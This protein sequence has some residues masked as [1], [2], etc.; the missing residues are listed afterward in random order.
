MP[1]SNVPAGLTS[2]MERCVEKVMAGGKDK[3]A[4]IA[5]CYKQVVGDGVR[6]AARERAKSA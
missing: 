2:K 6:S 5:I 3:K 1:Y 4:A